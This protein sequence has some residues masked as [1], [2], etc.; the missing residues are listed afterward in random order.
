ME[1]LRSLIALI[2]SALELAIIFH[3]ER[4]I[5]AADAGNP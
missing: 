5:V 3:G 4:M 1:V 2:H